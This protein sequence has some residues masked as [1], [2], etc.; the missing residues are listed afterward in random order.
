VARSHP[1]PTPPPHRTTAN[2]RSNAHAASPHASLPPAPPLPLPRSRFTLDRP[3]TR[4]IVADGASEDSRLL[5]LREDLR[6]SGPGGARPRLAAGGPGAAAREAALAAGGLVLR[7]CFLGGGFTRSAWGVCAGRSPPAQ[8]RAAH[9]AGWLHA[10]SC[11]RPRARP[12]HP[13]SSSRA[14]SAARAAARPHRGRRPRVVDVRTRVRLPPPGGGP[15]AQAAAAGG[16]GGADVVRER[17]PHR[18]FEPEGGGAALQAPHR[19]GGPP[20]GRGR[21]GS[22][23]AGAHM[24]PRGPRGWPCQRHA[25][26]CGCPGRRRSSARRALPTMPATLARA[27]LLPRSDAA[28][29]LFTTHTQVIIDKNPHITTVVNKVGTIQN[30]FR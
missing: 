13:N 18:A 2:A 3:K 9:P 6:E 30:E 4:C 1:H 22:G 5:L 8:R 20:G 10:C 23:P 7:R 19:A 14:R 25:R 11:Q 26:S 27:G 16:R 29:P 21:G 28:A 24:R 17:R 15:G 12:P